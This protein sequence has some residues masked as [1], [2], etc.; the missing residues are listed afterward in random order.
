VLEASWSSLEPSWNWLC[1]SVESSYQR[2]NST[3]PLGCASPCSCLEWIHHPSHI[4]WQQVST[5]TIQMV[6]ELNEWDIS[7]VR[8]TERTILSP[9]TKEY[10]ALGTLTGIPFFWNASHGAQQWSLNCVQ[11]SEVVQTCRCQREIKLD[12]GEWKF[13]LMRICVW[14]IRPGTATAVPDWSEQCYMK[15]YMGLHFESWEKAAT[16]CLS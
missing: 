9:F 10:R 7:R 16:M 15:I 6:L 5:Q 2:S 12:P 14:V 1:P 3:S 13:D 11:V 4:V 8:S